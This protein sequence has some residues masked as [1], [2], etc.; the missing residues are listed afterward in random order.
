MNI[1]SENEGKE[2]VASALKRE[3]DMARGHNVKVLFYQKEFDSRQIQTIN[4]QL[5]TEMVEIN[6]MGYEWSLE[7]RK[8]GNALTGT[9]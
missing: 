3:I 4:E 6:P 1:P 7:M 2:V 8:I 5:G 9:K